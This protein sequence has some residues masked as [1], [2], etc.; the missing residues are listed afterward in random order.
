MAVE[1]EEIDEYTFPESRY[2][3]PTWNGSLCLFLASDHHT[4]LAFTE[5]GDV[6][7]APMGELA[8][9]LVREHAAFSCF[10]PELQTVM[11]LCDQRYFEF[12]KR[13]LKIV[14]TRLDDGPIIRWSYRPEEGLSDP[15]AYSLA[16]FELMGWLRGLGIPIKRR[17]GWNTIA[18]KI[19]EVTDGAR[20][21]SS[22]I[23]ANGRDSFYGG[24]R[25]AKFAGRIGQVKQYDISAA[26]LSALGHHT[27][28]KSLVRVS[29]QSDEWK[30]PDHDGLI[31]ARVLAP[32][33]D[34]NVL[35]KRG[36]DHLP[37]LISFPS[38]EIEGYWPYAEFRL[39]MESG[40][41]LL[42][43][44]EQWAGRNEDFYFAK[45][46]EA[47]V[48]ARSLPNGAGK[49]AKQM[50]NSF[51]STFTA[52]NSQVTRRR[53]LE[54]F[55]KKSE[56]LSRRPRGK[57]YTAKTAFI[58]SIVS[59]RVRNQLYN[60]VLCPG[61]KPYPYVVHCDTDGAI[62]GGIANLPP[63]L[64]ETTTGPGEWRHVRNIPVLDLKDRNTYRYNCH[65][66]GSFDHPYWHYICTGSKNRDVAEHKFK[67]GGF[68]DMEPYDI[69]EI[70]LD[71]PQFHPKRRG[72]KSG[73]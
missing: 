69:E 62:V 65:D 73:K 37:R 16:F 21:L 44:L 41:I 35:P 67:S 24:R 18:S 12:T 50:A 38:G 46:A 2:R 22:P 28:P 26:Y 34:W 32:N 4:L 11:K 5:Y 39:A 3:Q 52:N 25:D 27:M 60:D 72:R 43:P 20:R 9:E 31:R 64:Q 71:D 19:W 42:E 47:M 48:A 15:Y 51:W 59:S 36:N 61:R 49:L 23:R 6:S 45:W 40:Y 33:N 14:E 55:G 8:R 57:P 66:C 58:S 30:I 56:L 63:A 10:S 70:D 54:Q 29:A 53:Y 68:D 1:I 13:N 17:Q 7:E